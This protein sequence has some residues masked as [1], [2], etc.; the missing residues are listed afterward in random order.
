MPVAQG[1]LAHYLRRD[2]DI[3]VGLREVSPWLPKETKPFRK[4]LADDTFG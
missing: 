3:V 1:V 2:K 4:S